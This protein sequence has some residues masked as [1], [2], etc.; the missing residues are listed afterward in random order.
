MKLELNH[1]SEIPLHLQVESIIREL[2]KEERYLNGELLPKEE[3]LAKKFAISRNTVR[4]ALNK[5]VYEGLLI[6]KKGKGTT[7]ASKTVSTRLD[8]WLSFTNEMKN[9][10]IEVRNFCLDIEF[11]KSDEKL[12]AMFEIP[13]NK[14]ILKL[15]RL[16]GTQES[17]IVFFISYFHPRVGLKGDEDFSQPLYH[18]LETEC[19]VAASLSREEISAIKADKNIAKKLRIKTGD[20]VLFRKRSVYDAGKRIIEYNLG[21]YRADSFTYAIDITR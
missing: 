18:M 3:D 8:N 12:S 16:R 10:G 19:S 11:V 9:K 6:R 7:V 1:N 2:I 20:P 13:L 4:H 5:L 17:P 14:E 15:E 21:Y